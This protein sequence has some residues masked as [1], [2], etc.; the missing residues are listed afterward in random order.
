MGSVSAP[1]GTDGYTAYHT[2]KGAVL[3]LMRAASAEFAARGVRVDAV[4]L[5]WVDTGFANQALA[6]LADGE[7]IR[8]NAGA[9]HLLGRVARP[10]EVAQAMLFLL[11]LTSPVSSPAR[12]WSSMAVSRGTRDGRS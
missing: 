4:S 9:K 8:R 1:I 10:D 3:G 6:E 2:S 11:F 5:G 12:N 7:K